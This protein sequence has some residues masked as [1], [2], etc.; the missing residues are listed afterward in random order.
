MTWNTDVNKCPPSAAQGLCTVC[1][2]VCV[3]VRVCAML[4]LVDVRVLKLH[5][6]LFFVRIHVQMWDFC[7]SVKSYVPAWM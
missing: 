4:L 1:V 7:I 2:C 6:Y 5:F 3:Y